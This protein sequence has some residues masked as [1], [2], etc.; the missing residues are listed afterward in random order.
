MFVGPSGAL[1]T[2]DLFLTARP[3]TAELVAGWCGFKRDGVV[4]FPDKPTLAQEAQEPSERL[5][6]LFDLPGAVDLLGLAVRV[7]AEASNPHRAE[8]YLGDPRTFLLPFLD[9][10]EVS[11]LRASALVWDTAVTCED[12]QGSRRS[13]RFQAKEALA[14]RGNGEALA[15]MIVS[16]RMARDFDAAENDVAGRALAPYLAEA[17]ARARAGSGGEAGDELA[18]AE[19]R[20]LRRR[21]NEARGTTVVAETRAGV[22]AVLGD[23]LAE[24]RRIP[25][26]EGMLA[27][28]HM[29]LLA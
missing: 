12:L 24:Y 10:V 20:Q 27:A 21:A 22:K 19:A 13:Y 8:D 6:D 17:R 14:S 28:E 3:G 25:G 18:L 5:L 9:V 1:V 2:S 4:F 15:R 7:F 11:V 23:L 29:A 26:V 16:Q